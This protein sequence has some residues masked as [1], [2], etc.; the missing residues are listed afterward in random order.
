MGQKGR[1]HFL[2][3]IPLWDSEQF[4]F[5]IGQGGMFKDLR[6]DYTKNMVDID[7]D[8]YSLG[9]LS[10]GEPIEINV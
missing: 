6:I 1:Q 4:Q 10:V 9:G 5:A 3:T 2:N 8:G 7:F